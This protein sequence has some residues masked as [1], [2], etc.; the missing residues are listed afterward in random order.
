MSNG[1]ALYLTLVVVSAL[2]FT[3]TLAWAT[4]QDGKG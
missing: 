4:L 2:A 3:V 1:E